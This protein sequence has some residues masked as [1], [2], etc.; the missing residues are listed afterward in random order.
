MMMSEEGLMKGIVRLCALVCLVALGLSCGGNSTLDDGEASVYLEI[1]ERDYGTSP[2]GSSNYY[3]PICSGFDVFLEKLTI[4]SKL[5]DPTAG[6]SPSQDVTLTRWE[7]TPYRSDGGT[8]SPVW[9]R[10]L[11]IH[12]PAGGSTDLDGFN[13]YPSEYYLQQ[14]LINLFPENGGFDPETGLRNIRQTL[15]VVFIGRTASGKGISV[16]TNLEY[17]FACT[18]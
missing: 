11:D 3:V 1:T 16:T 10:D 5:K 8:P 13:F 6:T 12:I 4:E 7:I 14:P 9:I 18:W 15:R 2:A 17:D